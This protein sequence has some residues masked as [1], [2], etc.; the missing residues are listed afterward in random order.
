MITIHNLQALQDQVH[1]LAKQGNDSE[2]MDA[3]ENI[4]EVDVGVTR[5]KHQSD[6]S[7][8]KKAVGSVAELKLWQVRGGTCCIFYY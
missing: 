6:N 4:T 5:D 1:H 3:E 8:Q 7:Q 2:E